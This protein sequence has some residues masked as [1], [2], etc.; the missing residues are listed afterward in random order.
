M[1]QVLEHL[2]EKLAEYAEAPLFAYLRDPNVE[3]RQKLSFAPHVAHFVL[4]FTDLCALTLP[5]EP[6]PDE[7][8]A[9]VNANAREDLEHWRWFLAD[10]DALGLNPTLPLNQAMQLV[11]SP[12][13]VR[14]R[15]LTYH[16]HHLTLG[17][18]SLEKVI[19]VRCIEGA[20]QVTVRDLAPVARD[21]Q[22]RTGIPLQYL[23]GPHFEAEENHTT[24]DEELSIPLQDLVLT[25]EESRELC[26]L[27]DR[28]LALFTGFADELLWLAQRD[29]EPGDVA[30]RAVAQTAASSA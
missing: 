18:N 23:G 12:E 13:T 29:A 28:A 2:D 20:F 25:P 11:W 22:A 5:Q 6:P 19:L 1:Q 24:E 4:G 27:I 3:P 14:T 7:Y 26:A 10:L 8:Q 21:Y 17:A 9:L 15:I 30:A 16:L